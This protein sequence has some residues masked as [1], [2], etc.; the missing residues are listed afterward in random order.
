[1]IDKLTRYNRFLFLVLYLRKEEDDNESKPTEPTEMS[2]WHRNM[3]MLEHVPFVMSC[4][5][6]VSVTSQRSSVVLGRFVI[7]NREFSLELGDERS[8][9]HRQLSDE[10]TQAVSKTSPKIFIELQVFNNILLLY[11]D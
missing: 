6:F 7:L 1:M 8:K 4:R 5:H 11:A 3:M 9:E 2:Q 10:V